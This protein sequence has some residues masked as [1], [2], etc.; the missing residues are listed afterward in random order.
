MSKISIPTFLDEGK[1][2]SWPNVINI[3]H[4]RW[5]SLVNKNSKRK[6]EKKK[7]LSEQEWYDRKVKD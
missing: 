1:L 4:L 6:K 7:K 2:K 5:V 3:S